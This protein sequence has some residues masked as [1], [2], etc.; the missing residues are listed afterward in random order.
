M[1]MCL[2]LRA[3][4]P[5]DRSMLWRQAWQ[6][7]GSQLKANELRLFAADARRRRAAALFLSR[8]T[9]E[10][11]TPPPFMTHVREVLGKIFLDPASCPVANEVVQALRIITKEQN[12][13]LPPWWSPNIFI[14]PPGDMLRA[15]SLAG[16]F[17]EKARDEYAAG[18]FVQG[19]LLLKAAVGYKWFKP[20]YSLPICFL[21]E[22]PTFLDCHGD[23]QN[24]CSPHGYVVVYLG[25]RTEKFRSVFDKLGACFNC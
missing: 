11:Y 13:L 20:A 4:D 19:I 10:H 7:R 3:F 22:R 25:P 23:P 5:R 1:K 2:A 15:D 18:H 8:E 24:G 9:V 12:G 6:R 17:F 14:N 21:H 16:R